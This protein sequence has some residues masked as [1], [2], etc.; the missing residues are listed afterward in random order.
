MA[1]PFIQTE[2]Q[3]QP[4][5]SPR[6]RDDARSFCFLRDAHTIANTHA[7]ALPPELLLASHFLYAFVL[8][9]TQR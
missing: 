8:L 3:P 7:A 5:I 4:H 9:R 1:G 2:T 6:L